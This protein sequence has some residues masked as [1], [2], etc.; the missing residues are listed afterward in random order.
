MTSSWKKNAMRMRNEVLAIVVSFYRAFGVIFPYF[1]GIGADKKVI[2]EEFP[3]PVSSRVEA[4]LPI[5]TRGK[6][7]ND[8]NACTGC[9]A[10]AVVCPAQCIALKAVESPDPDKKWVSQFDIDYSKCL[11]CGICVASC[12]PKSL[13]HTRV[14]VPG[15]IK[16]DA[17]V[18][19]FGKGEISPDQMEKWT[20][21]KEKSR[22]W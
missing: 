7:V 10:C 19:R 8:M 15:A 11:F 9:G 2:T 22:S 20:R 13:K 14:F 16:L 21:M 6:L 1:F 18:H 17:L 4:D 5:K 12:E 3:D